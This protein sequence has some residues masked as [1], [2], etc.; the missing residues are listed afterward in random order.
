MECH[1]NTVSNIVQRNFEV[2]CEQITRATG[3]QCYRNVGINDYT[4]YRTNC[5][6]T[7]RD[8]YYLGLF[9]EHLEG[10]T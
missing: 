1:G 2:P 3:H 10:G 7:T 6:I 9:L 4:G 5:P 8:D